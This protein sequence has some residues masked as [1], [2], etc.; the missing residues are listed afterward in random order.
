[1]PVDFNQSV[2]LNLAI[3]E[4][5][6]INNGNAYSITPSIFS[7]VI[8]SPDCDFNVT[9]NLQYN[10]S[11]FFDTNILD[12]FNNVTDNYFRI[13]G[14]DTTL[15]AISVM[16]V[17]SISGPLN[18]FGATTA[19]LRSNGSLDVSVLAGSSGNLQI[20]NAGSG[21]T[22]VIHSGF[23]SINVNASVGDINLTSGGRLFA[24]IAT[25]VIFNSTIG[26]I[27]LRAFAGDISLRADQLIDIISSNSD[28]NIDSNDVNITGNNDVNIT[29]TTGNIVVNSAANTLFLDGNSAVNVLSNG[30]VSIK[31]STFFT[32]VNVPHDGTAVTLFVNKDQGALALTLSCK[33][34]GVT[35]SNYQAPILGVKKVGTNGNINS[36]LELAGDATE[37]VVTS[38]LDGSSELTF[39]FNINVTGSYGAGST[40]MII[41]GIFS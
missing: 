9:G 1:M 40:Q 36:G 5:F 27:T 8:A 11:N 16:A 2:N 18:L 14:G 23:G 13:T 6:E 33:G 4:S 26:A 31:N 29:A 15:L 30:N 20:V 41:S 21:D 17:Q 3:G 28:I 39:N 24:N 35:G 10:I 22:E 19:N 38:W 7:T 12:S 25:D 32:E 37:L 34:D